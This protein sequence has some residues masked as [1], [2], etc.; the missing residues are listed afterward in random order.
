[1]EILQLSP[2]IANR[3][4]LRAYDPSR[5]VSQEHLDLLFEAARWAP[6]AFNEQPW[7][8]VY[9]HRGDEAFDRLLSCLAPS[10]ALWARNASVLLL[11]IGKKNS[12]HNGNYNRHYSHDVG[13]AMGLLSVQ[14][15]ELGLNLHQMGGYD[16]PKVEELFQ[17][18]DEFETISITSVGYAGNPDGLPETLQVKETAPRS[19]KSIDEIAFENH[20]RV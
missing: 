4:S 1:M 17:I 3:R 19:R 18:P 11:V 10:N 12:S 13:L 20:F 2:A 14:A 15:T 9:A 8:F 16:A 6:S 5:S 7:R